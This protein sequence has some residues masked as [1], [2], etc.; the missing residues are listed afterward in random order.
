MDDGTHN[1]TG[2]LIWY[3]YICQREVWLMAHEINA[4]QDNEFLEIGRILGESSYKREKKEIIFGNI[5]MDI[6]KRDAGGK[7]IIGEIKKSSRFQA[8]AANQLSYYLYRLKESGVEATGELLFP[9]EKKR[10]SIILDEAKEKELMTAMN[11]IKDIID[12]AKPPA[13]IKIKFCRNCAYA[14]F[15]WS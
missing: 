6:I 14:E 10:I 12:K 2:T 4:A 1:I 8:A 9:K 5:K 7:M 11:N 3:Y 15:C 13:A